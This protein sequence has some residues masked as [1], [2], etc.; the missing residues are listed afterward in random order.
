MLIDGLSII[1]PLFWGTID[2]NPS[3]H[4]ILIVLYK[5]SSYWDPISKPTILNQNMSSSVGMMT[6]PIYII[7]GKNKTCSKP[8][9]RCGCPGTRY[10]RIF[11][12]YRLIMIPESAIWWAP[13]LDPYHPKDV[14][15]SK[16][17]E[18]SNQS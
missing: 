2:G 14:F 4:P 3:H 6:F 18:T 16:K 17:H 11:R 9:T 12:I 7:Y 13:F 5:P 10:F 8:P 15:E 1:N